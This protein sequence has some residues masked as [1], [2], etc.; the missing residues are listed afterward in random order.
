[1]VLLFV[2]VEGLSAQ[3]K[4]G[5]PPGKIEPYSGSVT[6]LNG[7]STTDVS[8]SIQTQNDVSYPIPQTLKKLQLKILNDSGDIVYLRNFR[9]VPVTGNQVNVSVDDLQ[10]LMPVQ[11]Q[12]HIQTSNTVDEEVL[13]AGCTVLLRPDLVVDT[14][15][16]PASVHVSAPFDVEVVVGEVLTHSG[17]TASVSLC[18][19]ETV[20]ATA[21]GILVHAG[22]QVSV[23]FEGIQFSDAGTHSLK[24]RVHDAVPGEYD[25]GN[26]EAAFSVEVV[27]PM[28][29]VWYNLSYASKRNH[30]RNYTYTSTCGSYQQ[31]IL[32][33]NYDDLR[34]SAS[35]APSG[36]IPSP[37]DSIAVQI[38][39]NNGTV[40]NATV[41]N[42]APAS[43]NE[44]YDYYSVTVQD[45]GKPSFQVT[46]SASRTGSATLQ[47][48]KFARDYY[49]RVQNGNTISVTQQHDQMLNFEGLVE[50]RIALW[51]GVYAG[52]GKGTVQMQP[53]IP[54]MNYYYNSGGSW[55]CRWNSSFS[56]Y[57][58]YSSSYTSGYTDP[59]ILPGMDLARKDRDVAELFVPVTTDLMQN[60]P[61]PFNPS[62]NIQFTVEHS[63]PAVLKVYDMLGKEVEE[64]FRGE[65]EEGQPYRFT[66][67]GMNLASGMYYAKLEAGGRQ[68]VKKMLF[69]K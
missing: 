22:D 60:Y 35:F 40:L 43:S 4:K 44:S 42:I 61:N 56:E 51:D 29:A 12:A 67:H 6:A 1:V 34:Y 21:T 30:S 33:D 38:L 62:T 17:A 49:Y 48:Y 41:A 9:E 10:P 57:Y 27:N 36:P 39:S 5:K 18:E 37:I 16:A 64:L 54:Y 63:G 69:M 3:G 50:V 68:Y 46:L 14:V 11:I 59:E 28:V 66:F 32:N 7:P 53:F 2:L 65:V 58:Q 20:I 47:I 52:G 26:N 23:L 25:T 13:K 55:F 45:P 8:V 19:G 24:A 31:E 15:R